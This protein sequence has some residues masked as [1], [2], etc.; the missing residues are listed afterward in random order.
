MAERRLLFILNTLNHSGAEVMLATAAPLW[1]NHGWTADILSAGQTPGDFASHLEAA[2]YRL[3]HLRFARSPLFLWR[4][5]RFFRRTRFDA[6]H[7]HTEQAG[8]W[9]ALAAF[10]TG[11]RTILRTVHATF[12]FTGSLRARRALQ[13]RIMRR[14]FGAAMTAPSR[15][16]QTNEAQTF[17]NPVR[18]VPNWIDTGRFRPPD[19]VERQAARRAFDQ[20]ADRFVI[21][22]VGNCSPIK[23]HR[24]MIEALA[25]LP[26]DLAWTWLH[27]GTGEDEATERKMAAQSGLDDR[28]R[29]LGRCDPRPALWAA[30]CFVMPSMRE[31]LG[32]AAAEALACGL[33]C[34]LA[35]RPGLRD[36]APYAEAILWTAPEPA[37]IAAAVEAA[38][39][40]ERTGTAGFADVAQRVHK[41][42][43]PERG[44]SAFCE[45]YS[46][47][48]HDPER[49]RNEAP[50]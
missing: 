47:G 31:G 26:P 12:S 28:I 15:S 27:V 18:I 37:A 2:G 17:G 33:R 25:L 48:R 42:F 20:P 32:L 16:V 9:Y 39:G 34:V 11:H 4:L 40:S 21:V 3:H 13:R 10:L 7:I 35:D 8:F 46:A 44:V 19:A 6:V 43:S 1:A 50:Q 29:F 45:L 36:F 30:D 49:L 41:D 5:L 38:A 22:S 14:V 23:N 24:A